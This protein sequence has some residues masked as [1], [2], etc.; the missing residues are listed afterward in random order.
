M[1]SENA[2]FSQHKNLKWNKGNKPDDDLPPKPGRGSFLIGV[3]L[4]LD[5]FT[6]D[7]VATGHAKEVMNNV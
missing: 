4:S 1:D 3:T 5:S 2:S 6:V 7:A